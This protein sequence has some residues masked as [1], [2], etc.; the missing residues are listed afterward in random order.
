MEIENIKITKKDNYAALR[1]MV[2][3][4]YDTIG[5]TTAK[6]LLA[7]IDHEVELIDQRAAKSK[8]YQQEHK[9]TDDAMTDEIVKVLSTADGAL[10]IPDIVAK[11]EDSTPQK[12][13]Y[14]LGRL[15]KANLISREAK[16]IKPDDG[17]A[18][19]LTYY[20]MIR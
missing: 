15:A 14:R 13:T 11:I 9:A 6:R 16:T 18:R 3:D 7:F 10:T 17:P 8:Q 2:E 1:A 12:I 20:T 19:R 4:S 5:E